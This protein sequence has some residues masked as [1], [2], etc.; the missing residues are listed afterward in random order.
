L[1]TTITLSILASLLTSI[2]IHAQEAQSPDEIEKALGLNKPT[3]RSA[4]PI[5]SQVIK[6]KATPRSYQI[7]TRGAPIIQAT[8][9]VPENIKQPVAN[10]T[11]EVAVPVQ[12]GKEI[13]FSNILFEI[14]STQFA[15]HL[16]ISQIAEIAQVMENHPKI[17]FV[18]EGHTC[19]LGSDHD[20]EKLSIQRAAVV[21][22]LLIRYGAH[23]NQIIAFGF[24]EKQPLIF[25]NPSD[26]SQS[27]EENR[28]KNRRVNVRLGNWN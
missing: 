1:K 27:A 16:S 15:D 17:K 28:Q 5:K 26:R 11:G 18:I 24:G 22:D 23:P 8:E 19:D 25:V 3:T 13:N 7:A 4:I 21:E 2:Q 12:T 6:G 20:N 14:N 10:T 9:E